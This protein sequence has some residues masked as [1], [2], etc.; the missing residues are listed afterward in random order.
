[1]A[2]LRYIC[3]CMGITAVFGSPFLQDHH[4]DARSAT[5]EMETCNG[6]INQR[7]SILYGLL[8]ANRTNRAMFLPKLRLNGRQFVEDDV[9]ADGIVPFSHFYDV[10]H[11]VATISSY[12]TLLTD[13]EARPTATF[14]KPGDL[15]RGVANSSAHVHLACPLFHLERD[16]VLQHKPLVLAWLQAFEPAPRFHV[17]LQA[18]TARMEHGQ[19]N[20]VH[21]R[22]EQDCT[23]SYHSYG[24]TIAAVNRGQALPEVAQ[25]PQGQQLRHQHR[26]GGHLFG[27]RRG[28][29]VTAALHGHGNGQSGRGASQ[30]GAH[31]LGSDGLL[32][33]GERN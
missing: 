11:F 13:S 23:W 8:F 22:A 7:I 29:N 10:E 31:V 1:M 32:G 12:V 30:Q 16:I 9:S 5:L 6:F 28:R 20:F 33:E 19:Y 18:A 14:V 4:D 15:Q 21:W 17:L 25:G 26:R 24:Y 3:I 2:F 27:R